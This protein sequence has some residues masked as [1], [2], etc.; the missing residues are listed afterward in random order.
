MPHSSPP[1]ATA[2]R[3]H[4]AK[5]NPRQLLFLI[6]NTQEARTYTILYY[7]YVH[8]YVSIAYIGCAY[9]HCKIPSDIRIQRDAQRE[10]K[11][12]SMLYVRFCRQQ[13]NAF[14]SK[15]AH[16]N[17]VD[18]QRDS[19]QTYAPVHRF[20]SLVGHPRVEYDC[21]TTLC[22]LGGISTFSAVALS[23]AYYGIVSTQYRQH[24]T[25]NLA[26]LQPR[27]AAGSVDDNARISQ[28]RECNS[29][30]L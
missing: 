25:G 7:V 26:L 6:Q 18:T 16:E 30:M 1:I 29:Q 10:A 13:M 4:I 3:Q 27:V 20:T 22:V 21:K 12:Q 9:V 11:F 28:P 24:M 17:V 19:T 2:H 23:M 8:V 5:F 15:H 14:S